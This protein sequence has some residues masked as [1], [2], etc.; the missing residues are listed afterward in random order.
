MSTGKVRITA[1]WTCWRAVGAAECKLA[2]A[3]Q[4]P[5]ETGGEVILY[6]LPGVPS[7][8]CSAHCSSAHCALQGMIT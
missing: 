6:D 2:V 8:R 3:Q 5:V 1:A 4:H 7:R